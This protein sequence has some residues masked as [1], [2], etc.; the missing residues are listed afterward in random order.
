MQLQ[1]RCSS[2]QQQSTNQLCFAVRCAMPCCVVLR[3]PI[4][5]G[6]IAD[7]SSGNVAIDMYHRWEEDIA[8]MKA[9]GVKNY[10]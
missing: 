1:A 3:T 2:T 7:N 10:R 4:T 8:L 6:K 5:T 9:L